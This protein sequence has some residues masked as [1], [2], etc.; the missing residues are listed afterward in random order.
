M[1]HFGNYSQY[2]DLLYKNKDYKAEA[3]YVVS[4]LRQYSP[5]PVK[6]ILDIGCG[7]GAHDVFLNKAGLEITGLD[8]SEN[9]ISIAKANYGN[10]KNLSFVAGDSKSFNLS[11]KFDAVISLFHVV[12]YNTKNEELLSTFKNVHAHLK[13]QGIFVFDFWYG[14]GVL[15][16][17]PSD[18]EKVMEDDK[19]HILRKTRSVTHF[20]ENV[21]DV[22][23]N[24]VV[25]SKEGHPS[26]ILNELHKV[27][28]FFYPELQHFLKEAGFR[29]TRILKWMSKEEQPGNQDWYALVIAQK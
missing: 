5:I 21:V 16:D 29:E 14:P 6:S 28:Y 15:Q 12:S 26:Y 10:I 8:L 27:R 3:D 11:S 24:V 20:H 22:N 23:F 7:T 1:G 13:E 9:M 18:R 2:Y 4:L 25:N 17:L 19:I